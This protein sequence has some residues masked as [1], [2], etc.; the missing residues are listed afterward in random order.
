[1]NSSSIFGVLKNPSAVSPMVE[2][3]ILDYLDERNLKERTNVLHLA[4]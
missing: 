2:P 4:W 1:M 3:P